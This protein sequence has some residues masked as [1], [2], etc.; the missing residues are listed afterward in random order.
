MVPWNILSKPEQLDEIVTES[1]RIAVVIYKHSLRCGVSS[2]AKRALDQD[3]D[4]Q[5]DELKPYYLDVIGSRSLSDR[6]AQQFKVRH[7]S[8]Q[9]MLIRNG[10]VIYTNSHWQISVNALREALK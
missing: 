9:I 5:P 7:E 4:L 10:K 1:R 2:A 8:P 3:W 6:V